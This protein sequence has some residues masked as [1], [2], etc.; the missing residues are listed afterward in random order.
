MF[1]D[2]AGRPGVRTCGAYALGISLSIVTLM[3]TVY[4]LV[5]ALL[6]P[7]LVTAASKPH[8]VVL[9]KIQNVK[10]F[11]GSAE[12]KTVDIRIRPLYV[13]TKLKEFTTGESHDV[14]D[15]EFVVQRVFRINDT[16]PEDTRKSPK[17]MWQRGGWLLVDRVSGKIVPVKLPDFDPYYSEISWYRDYAAYCGV[18]SSGERVIAAVFEIGGK[19]A[20]FRKDVAKNSL[21]EAF[22]SNCSAPHWDRQ[23]ARVTFLPKGGDK[24][25][26]NVSGRFAD[27]ASENDTEEQ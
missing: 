22:D 20:L 7:S 21:G 23:P 26:V 13:D 6:V 5:I 12:D 14:T 2:R 17:W 25:T 4:C 3:R 19:K 24:F 1:L 16:L 27:Q 18:S 10:L 8:V 15:R 9:G 11:I